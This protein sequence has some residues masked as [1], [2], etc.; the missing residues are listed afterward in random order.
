M[1]FQ[2]NVGITIEGK[3]MKKLLRIVVLIG[4]THLK[5]RSDCDQTPFCNLKKSSKG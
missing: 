2:L 5:L 3:I 1:I 4:K